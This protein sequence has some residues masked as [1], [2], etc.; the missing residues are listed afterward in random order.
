MGIDINQHD[1][2]GHIGVDNNGNAYV[3]AT[4]NYPSYGDY[5]LLKY[6]SSGTLLWSRVFNSDE[7]D[8]V[9]DLIVSGQGVATIT[10]QKNKITLPSAGFALT[11]SYDTNGNLLWSD[12]FAD[13]A[14]YNY[15]GFKICEGKAGNIFVQVGAFENS[16][17]S[18]PRDYVTIKYDSTG[19]KQWVQTYSN[20][21]KGGSLGLG[22]AY[23]D[24]TSDLYAVGGG[25]DLPLTLIQY[26]PNGTVKSTKNF[27]NTNS[28]APTIGSNMAIDK[29]GKGYILSPFKLFSF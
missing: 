6:D 25:Y 13:K 21:Q 15:F 24:L 17:T 10:G 18:V 7:N 22:I 8:S 12:A 29:T 2:A 9:D 3:A 11:V 16:G 26:A 19:A 5:V 23:S 14:N 28:I 4:A 27:P 20:A 1:M